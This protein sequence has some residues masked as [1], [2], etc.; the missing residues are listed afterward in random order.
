[1]EYLILEDKERKKQLKKE[2][3]EINKRLHKPKR[4]NAKPQVKK[5]RKKRFI[6]SEEVGRECNR[7]GMV[8]ERREHIT[9]PNKTWYYTKWDY[10]SN[11]SCEKTVQ[12]YDE[13]K[14]ED[15]KEG[16]RQEEFLANIK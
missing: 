10:C 14:S 12:H 5:E 6:V 11:G 7:C 4:K 15:W 3:K 13:F 8:M 16:E 9:K 1:M 2:L